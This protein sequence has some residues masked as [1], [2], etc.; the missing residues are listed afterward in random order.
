MDKM[1]AGAQLRR[2][3]EDRRM[4]QAELARVLEISPSYLNQ[5][6]HNSRPL[7]VPVLLK[8]TEIFG[9]DTH[10]FAAQDTARLIADLREAFG[11]NT[12]DLGLSATEAAELAERLPNSARAFVQLHERYRQASERLAMLTASDRDDHVTP[13]SM[14][15]EEARDYFYQRQNYVPDLD[16]AAE[17]L[18]AEIGW[19]R[20][21]VR[22]AIEN[23]LAMHGIRVRFDPEHDKLHRFS[24]E[25]QTLH[26]ST[27]LKP[28]QVAYR[29]ATQLALTEY[30]DLL[31]RLT[32]ENEYTADESRVLTKIGLAN[33]FA[34]ALI[35][36]Y[37]IFHT[38]AERF[39]Y[40]I[41]M[42]STH[43]SL[44]WETICHR[45]STLQR[46]RARGVPF[47]FIRVDRAGNMSKRQSATGFH[48]SRVGGSCP[49]W[50]VYE[51]FSSPGKILTQIAVMPDGRRY[52]WIART[53]TR[54]PGKWNAPGKTYAVAL[55]CELRQ[56][57]RLIY[58]TG[59]DL[60]NEEAATPIGIGCKVCERT[61]CPQRAFPQFGRALSLDENHSTFIP[62]PVGDAERNKAPESTMYLG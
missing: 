49:L 21:E 53:V 30:D 4:S 19:R 32:D 51:A 36:P 46:P 58:S 39:R 33:Y 61:S 6:E 10:F 40:D 41:E 23:R 31:N 60:D 34:A 28:G 26:L 55:G 45:L 7:T 27:H 42:L 8:I 22:S 3:R 25:E 43:F 11:D 54:S 48:F 1:Y 35:L 13:Q 47:S 15:H 52:F 44:G 56:A 17:S 29:M 5:I 59:L 50:I 2:L 20:G 24:P 14:P 37:K 18:A 57:G 16:S 9:V 62:Y 38:T 12:L